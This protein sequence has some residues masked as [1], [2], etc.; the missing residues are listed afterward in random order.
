MQ[1]SISIDRLRFFA[2]HGVLDA[3]RRIGNDFEVSLRLFY[4]ASAAMTTDLVDH[5]LDYSAVVDIV[6]TVMA[7]P[8]MLIENVA[9]RIMQALKARFPVITSGSITVTK[10]LPPMKCQMAGASFTVD[11]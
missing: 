6:A 3:E 5:A 10:L 9:W 4:D 11:F 2:R 8:S 7:T 1:T